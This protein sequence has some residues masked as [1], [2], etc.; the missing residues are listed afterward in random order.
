[1][2]G[3]V[4]LGFLN[5]DTIDEV[6]TIRSTPALTPAFKTLS[7]PSIAGGTN[8]SLFLEVFNGNGD[9]TCI[10]YLQPL[11]ASFQPSSFKRS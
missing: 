5:I 3:F 4:L 6:L 10:I 8:P 2:Y 7:V 1:M 11:A 9:A